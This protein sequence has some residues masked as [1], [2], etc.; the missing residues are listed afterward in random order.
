M[1]KIL[2]DTCVWLDLAKDYQQQALLA[3]LEELVQQGE[4]E[5][6]LPRTIIDE[7]ARNKDRVIEQSSRSI[8]STLKRV[9]EVV[10]KFG[11]PQQKSVVISQLNDVD[12]R[13]PILG[14]AAVD[15]VS[16]IERLFSSTPTIE[17]SDAVKLRAAQRAIDKRA[18]FHRQ[19]NS[20]DDAILIEIYADLIEQNEV[21]GNQFAFL[22]HNTHDFSHPYANKKLPHPDIEAYFSTTRSLYFISLSE[23]L[24]YI[25]PEQ[26][27]DLMIEHYWV[28][29]PRR[30]TE[31]VE[32]IDEFA[33]KV[34]YNR[35]QVRREKI[36]AGIVEIV[37][38]E[39]FPIKNHETRP[40]Q[41]DIWEG[42]LRSAARVEE[43][44][45]LDDLGPWDDF[46]WGMINGK[47]SALRWVLGDEWDMLDT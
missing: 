10:E 15:M 46:E 36:E 9:K 18:P 25:Q 12:H 4:I 35:H 8:S 38:K 17:I 16:R 37:E 20:I 27:E 31:I 14:E 23:A 45:G 11:D 26:F 1:F 28:E 42:A 21:A 13:L 32:A 7:F 29:E 3:A 6:V 22:S 40:I 43:R 19:R 44:F 47:L 24:Q 41:R 33:T 39:H 5:L 30:L 2:I 34:W